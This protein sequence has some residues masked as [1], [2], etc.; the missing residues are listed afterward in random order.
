[1]TAVRKGAVNSARGIIL[2]NKPRGMTSFGVVSRLRRLTG[3][4]RIGHCGTLDPFAVGL[5]PVCIGRATAAVQ[6][7]DGYDKT[8]LVKAVFGRATDSM[9]VDGTTIEER[10]L[11]ADEINEMKA[12]NYSI[13]YSGVTSMIGT[14][15]QTP[16]MYSAVKV[17]G[18]PL[19]SYAREGKDIERKSRLI[20]VYNAD[21][22]SIQADPESGYLAA[23]IRISCSKGTYIRV[24]I[25]DLGRKTG[26]LAYAESLVRESCG[27]Y[28]LAQANDIEQLFDVSR[29]LPDQAAFVNLIRNDGRLLPVA[30]AFAGYFSIEATCEDAVKL[31]QGKTISVLPYEITDKQINSDSLLAVFFKEELIAVARIELDEHQA[32]WLKT[33]RV[34]TDLEDF[35]SI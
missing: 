24:L 12:D 18:R 5:L 10:S 19:Y 35:R 6:F 17:D 13:I 31:I 30:S 7:M 26:L 4:K 3:I 32:A 11:N 25:D 29:Q 33:E 28:Q 14:Q 8:Y 23:D 2:I 9:D 27:P 20:E 34:F 16:P 22:I 1:M 15:Q 21:I